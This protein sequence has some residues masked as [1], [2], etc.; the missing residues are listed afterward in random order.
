MTGSPIITETGQVRSNLY[1][2][3]SS[4]SSVT[5]TCSDVDAGDQVGMSEESKGACKFYLSRISR[6]MY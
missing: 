3:L 5:S 2:G 4:V 1:I 6:M